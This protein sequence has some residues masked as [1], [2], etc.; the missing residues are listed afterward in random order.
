MGQWAGKIGPVLLVPIEVWLRF[1]VRSARPLLTTHP[2]SSTG[3]LPPE[4]EKLM[5]T[6]HWGVG[7][8]PLRP[9][10][11][12]GVVPYCDGMMICW[13]ARG[14]GA[15]LSPSSWSWLFVISVGRRQWLCAEAGRR[16]A[17]PITLGR[18]TGVMMASGDGGAILI[19]ML[20][21]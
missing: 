21:P 7:P 20:L 11:N 14:G 18:R 9:T 2:R 19:S 5:T 10:C 1:I 15:A 4:T 12:L 6:P 13:V 17:P 3:R 16:A 8:S